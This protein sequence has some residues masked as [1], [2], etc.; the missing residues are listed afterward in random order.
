MVVGLLG[1]AISLGVIKS[2]SDHSKKL[3]HKNKSKKKKFKIKKSEKKKYII[4]L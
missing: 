2:V 1:V 4:K 3:K